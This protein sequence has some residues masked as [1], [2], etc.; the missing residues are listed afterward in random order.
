MMPPKP[1]RSSASDVMGV[2]DV[3]DTPAP[4]PSP[5]PGQMQGQYAFHPPNQTLA[6]V[7]TDPERVPE[8][9]VRRYA[10]RHHSVYTY[11]ESVVTSHHMM[12]LRPRAT[13]VQTVE[14]FELLATPD[15]GYH[16]DE[17]D[18][19]GNRRTRFSFWRSYRRLEL[20]ASS[21]VRVR[22]E[23]TEETTGETTE[24]SAKEGTEGTVTLP[25]RLL[26]SQPWDANTSPVAH[27]M[28]EWTLPS[29]HVPVGPNFAA[30][31]QSTLTPGR[32]LIDGALAM[33]KHI[34]DTFVYDTT[35]TTIA[36][37][38]AEVLQR[39]RG[40]CQDFSHVM[41]SALRSLGIPCRYVSGYLET[42][43]PAGRQRLRGADASHAWVS[44][45]DPVLGW[46][47]LDPTN[48]CLVGG[49]HI[50]LSWGRDFADV[51]PITGVIL[52]GGNQ[53]VTVGVDVIPDTE[54]A[55]HGISQN[56]LFPEDL[57][58]VPR[59]A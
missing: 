11:Q 22:Q 56:G 6:P 10:L 21:V 44:V 35:A 59:N 9:G 2:G 46:V 12:Y 48:G 51:S 20:T 7:G 37:P 49:R 13:A 32:P 34:Q 36:T 18:W 42:V 43:P 55:Q 27:D 58:R 15:V 3:V 40:V 4:L 29:T 25:E 50:T 41:L 31:G 14:R 54:W 33:A 30:F 53:L 17:F 1:N 57:R 38:A 26:G 47:D 39:R 45:F 16:A 19:F 5:L 52:G 8:T 28:V 23:S 24:G